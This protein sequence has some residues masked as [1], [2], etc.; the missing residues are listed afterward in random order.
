MR[1]RLLTVRDV[2]KE[3]QCSERHVYNLIKNGHLNAR[4]LGRKMLRVDQSDLEAF[5]EAAQIQTMSDPTPPQDS[6]PSIPRHL[7]FP[8]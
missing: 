5:I 8:R 2:A 1:G 7:R 3:L 6:P 4:R